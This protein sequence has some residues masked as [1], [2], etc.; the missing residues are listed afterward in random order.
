MNDFYK[1]HKDVFTQD[2]LQEYLLWSKAM[3]IMSGKNNTHYNI[4]WDI[5]NLL[6]KVDYQSELMF[7]GMINLK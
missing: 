5:L 6:D 1:R 7:L 3:L 4:W 2:Q